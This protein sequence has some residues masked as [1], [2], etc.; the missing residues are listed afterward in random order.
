MENRIKVDNIIYLNF[1]K[2]LDEIKRTEEA[3][4]SSNALV[5]DSQGRPFDKLFD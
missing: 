5:N 2:M 4:D 1:F 3:I